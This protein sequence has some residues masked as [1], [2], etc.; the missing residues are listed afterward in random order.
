MKCKSTRCKREIPDNAIF[1]PWCGFRQVLAADEV[2]VPQP[3]RKGNKWYAQMMVGDQRVYISEDS[4]EEYYAKA[5]A[6]KTRQLAIKKAAPRITLGAVI[7]KLLHGIPEGTGTKDIQTQVKSIYPEPLDDA[8]QPFIS[9][10]SFQRA[11]SRQS[12]TMVAGN[13]WCVLCGL[14]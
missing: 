3:K 4:E 11:D 10:G 7:D 1:C 14:G 9:L 8:K 12:E 13:L 2:K 5:N 6:I